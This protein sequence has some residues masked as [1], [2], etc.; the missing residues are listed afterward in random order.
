MG[1]LFYLCLRIL[2][3][4]SVWNVAEPS[5][6]RDDIGASKIT[7]RCAN[8]SLNYISSGSRRKPV[9][10]P[11]DC[12]VVSASVAAHWTV[13]GRKNLSTQENE[14][15]IFAGVRIL[16]HGI[17]RN[18]KELLPAHRHILCLFPLN[19]SQGCFFFA[20]VL[21][22]WHESLFVMFANL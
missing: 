10:R 19:S 9:A 17:K 7:A 3:L 6:C 12:E 11:Q 13:S 18:G 4:C 21:I 22:D 15:D 1:F 14:T 5:P 8:C 20:G 2:Q 16:C